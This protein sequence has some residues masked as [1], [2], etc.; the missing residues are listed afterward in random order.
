MIIANW[1]QFSPIT[2]NQAIKLKEVSQP[3]TLLFTVISSPS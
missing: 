2:P 1:F 3:K